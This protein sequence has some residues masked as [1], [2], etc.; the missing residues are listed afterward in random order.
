[1][2]ACGKS[3]DPTG[4]LLETA[5][6]SP[7]HPYAGHW[8]ERACD[9]DFGLAIAPAGPAT[10]SV[11]FCGPGGCFKP[12]TYRPNTTIVRDSNYRI[13]GPDVIE[14]S[15]SDGFARYVRCKPQDSL[16]RALKS[17]Q[18]D[19]V[20][21]VIA[22]APDAEALLYR[23]ELHEIGKCASQDMSQADSLYLQ[24]AKAGNAEAM[25]SVWHKMAKRVGGPNP[26]TDA[27]RADALSWLFRA[28]E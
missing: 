16:I 26:P 1:M 22:T 28:G 12:G 9:H 5:V 17:G 15:G 27:E 3:H 19:A 18:C 10:Y 24:A 25:F 13:R 14:V 6:A 2:S 8:Q 23:A 4:T 11:S 7:E 21:K 20:E